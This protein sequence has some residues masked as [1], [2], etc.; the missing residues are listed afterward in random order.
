MRH[1]LLVLFYRKNSVIEF[2]DLVTTD[3]RESSIN[4]LDT[5]LATMEVID[6]IRRQLGVTY[7][8]DL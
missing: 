8:A 4:T 6:E 3:Q 2:I 7:P 5:T 1:K